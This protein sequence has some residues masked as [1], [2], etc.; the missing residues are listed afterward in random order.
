MA[1][2]LLISRR[3]TRTSSLLLIIVAVGISILVK[4]QS[5]SKAQKGST[6]FT[7]RNKKL[8]SICPTRSPSSPSALW[9]P[10]W[11]SPGTGPGAAAGSLASAECLWT[12][13]PPDCSSWTRGFQSVISDHCFYLN[14]NSLTV[15]APSIC[16]LWLRLRGTGGSWQAGTGAWTG[17]ARWS[18]SEITRR[19][20]EKLRRW[21]CK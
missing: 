11:R 20:L 8:T 1:L 2:I 5:F 17:K 7:D 9:A 16:R 19:S 14:L 15:S 21:L 3:F 12:F 13:W 18:N 6:F 4:S 10:C